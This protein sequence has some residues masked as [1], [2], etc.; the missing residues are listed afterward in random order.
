MNYLKSLVMN[1]YFNLFAGKG[2]LKLLLTDTAI[3]IRKSLSVDNCKSLI[4]DFE[5]SLNE[6]SA[7]IW[8][9]KDGSDVRIYD[10]KSTGLD[11][12]NLLDLPRKKKNIEMYTGRKIK[13]EFLMMNKVTYVEGNKGS[14]GGVHRDSPYSHQIKYIWYLN[15]VGPNNGPFAYEKGSNRVPWIRKIKTRYESFIDKEKVSIVQGT[16]G[17]LI[18]AD[19]KCIHQGMPVVEGQRYAI[20]Y[21]TSPDRQAFKKHLKK[22]KI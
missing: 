2:P 19:T 6:K 22:L 5:N 15:D 17:T 8:V 4:A 7:N 10:F 12:K 16:A 21:Y 3:V 11:L 18:I 20:T 14:G 1:T 13:N 9:S